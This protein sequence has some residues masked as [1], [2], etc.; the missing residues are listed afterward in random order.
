MVLQA[1]NAGTLYMH[2][3]TYKPKPKDFALTFQFL[4]LNVHYKFSN[5]F[6]V[7]KLT[8]LRRMEFPNLID[9]TGQFQGVVGV[10]FFNIMSASIGD[11]GQTP[12]S[13]ASDLGLH[14]LPIFHL[15]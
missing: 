11:P 7:Q 12:R 2:T 15:K 1:S 8:R 3:T 5:K 10:V 14:C 6:C 13:A 9:W 4:D